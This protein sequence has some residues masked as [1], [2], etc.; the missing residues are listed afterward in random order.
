MAAVMA[1]ARVEAVMEV[2]TAAAA[3]VAAMV[4]AEMAAATVAMGGDGGGDGGGA[5]GGGEGGDGTGREAERATAHHWKMG[6]EAS[7]AREALVAIRR[8]T[9][10]RTAK[11]RRLWRGGGMGEGCDRRDA[12]GTSLAPPTKPQRPRILSN[13]L[14]VCSFDAAEIAA[15]SPGGTG[16]AC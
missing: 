5:G 8:G 11:A 14:K 13:C 1:V 10:A 4:A 7:E 15:R 9:E 3:M 12:G 16:T 6:I 2:E